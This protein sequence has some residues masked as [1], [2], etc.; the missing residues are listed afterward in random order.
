[1]RVHLSQSDHRY[2]QKKVAEMEASDNPL[3]FVERFTGGFAY[4]T[5]RTTGLNTTTLRKMRDG[6]RPTKAQLAA[7]RFALIESI[8]NLGYWPED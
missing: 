6:K 7:L 1:M 8:L 3:A 4:D 5:A 2:I